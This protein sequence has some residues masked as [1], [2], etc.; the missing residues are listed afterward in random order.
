MVAGTK[1][2][3]AAALI[4]AVAGIGGAAFAT[5]Y[6]VT[7][8]V[9]LEDRGDWVVE[10]D[11]VSVETTY[12]LYVSDELKLNISR[13]NVDY[14]LKMNGVE[15]ARGSKERLV[16]QKGNSTGSIQT[17][18]LTSNV[19]RWWATHLQNG[20]KS[21][22]SI[23][24]AVEFNL[25]PVN[26]DFAARAYTDTIETDLES[27]L[28]SA[29]GSIEGNYTGP[30][31]VPGPL[32]TAT[33]PEIVIKKAS[34]EWGS[35]TVENTNL[36]VHTTIKNPN[37][38]PIPVPGFEGALE[39]NGITVAEWTAEDTRAISSKRALAPSEQKEVTF[40]VRIDNQEMK[41]WFITHVRNGERTGATLTSRMVFS[42]ENMDVKI[43]GGDGMT[44]SFSFRT[45]ILV[46]NQNSSSNFEGCQKPGVYQESSGENS[47]SSSDDSDS[48][49]GST[50]GSGLIGG[51]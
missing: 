44:C 12:W 30:E 18:L 16:L 32:S 35:V 21:R 19:P 9:G 5:G 23:P 33:R 42:F 50:G 46:D 43:P 34:A 8:D 3:I 48:D 51:L 49:S 20:E 4:V 15:L 36:L 28:D 41:E 31:M 47:D 11:D 6:I 22:L 38:Y 14:R 39:M 10:G 37:S 7:P 26:P 27:I 2:K 40:R 45:G 25:G 1:L 29:V 17:R 13:V 24:A